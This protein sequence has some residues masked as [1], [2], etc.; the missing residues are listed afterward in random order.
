M[1][2]LCVLSQGDA[3]CIHSRAPERLCA[4]GVAVLVPGEFSHRAAQLPLPTP[5][6][7]PGGDISAPRYRG[8]PNTLC[9]RLCI[10]LHELHTSDDWHIVAAEGPSL[11]CF[12]ARF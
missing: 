7:P 6:H 2:Y 5:D 9:N 4:D 1:S 3:E 10:A 8:S 11:R 12:A